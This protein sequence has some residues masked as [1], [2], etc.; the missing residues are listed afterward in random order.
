MEPVSYTHLDVYKRQLYDWFL[1]ELEIEEPPR[2]IEFARLNLNYTLTSKRRCLA[3][4]N[5]GVVSGWDDPRM[6][7]LC[8]MRRRGYPAEAIREF[9]KK[10]GVS[11]AYSVV[12]FSLL[13]HCVRDNLN[14]NAPRAM[15]VLHPVKVII[16]NYPEGKTEAILV[17]V[18]PD[19]P[20]L[21]TV[22]YT[23][24]SYL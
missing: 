10:I 2:Q 6:S 20:E 13:E 8:G 23:H 21:G 1:K 16:D 7:T 5:E 18:H 12:D 22:S 24:L 19:R 9:C 14:Q 4:V 15:A 3:L 17:D 11:K